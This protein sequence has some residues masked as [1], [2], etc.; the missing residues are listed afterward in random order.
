MKPCFDIKGRQIEAGDLLRSEH[1]MLLKKKLY[2]YHVAMVR[3]GH[4]YAVP[5]KEAIGGKPDGGVVNLGC[6]GCEFEIID[7][8]MHEEN[9]IIKMWCERPR[10]KNAETT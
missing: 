1:F 7:G 10:R 5:L 6:T 3:D 2:L 8:P 4:L 9:G